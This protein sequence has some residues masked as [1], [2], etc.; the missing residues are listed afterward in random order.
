MVH[1]SLTL[2]LMSFSLQ[3]DSI[4][5]AIGQSLGYSDGLRGNPLYSPHGLNVSLTEKKGFLASITEE[6]L[7]SDIKQTQIHTKSSGAKVH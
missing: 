3:G 6:M 4:R 1:G 7:N 2:T 5:H